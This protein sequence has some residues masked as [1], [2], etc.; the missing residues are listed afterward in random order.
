M[1][2]LVIICPRCGRAMEMQV[3]TDSVFNGGMMCK[4]YLRIT[5]TVDVLSLDRAPDSEPH[6]VKVKHE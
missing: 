3:N 4:C 2:R 6:K 5:F 1:N